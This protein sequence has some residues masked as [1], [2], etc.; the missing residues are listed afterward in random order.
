[1]AKSLEVARSILIKIYVISLALC[2][3]GVIG[4]F[5]AGLL[6]PQSFIEIILKAIAIYS[7]PFGIIGA[8]TYGQRNE[9]FARSTS[10]SFNTAFVLS[11]LW[12]FLIV[13]GY[14]LLIVGGMRYND[15]QQYLAQVVPTSSWLMAGGLT[16]F[17]S[18]RKEVN[19][20]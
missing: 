11:L 10:L 16:F 6:E 18:S 9:P 17:F 15:L 5:F 20:E 3:F 13:L 4:T 2:I 12:N 14:M 19:G 1:M 8:G 7:V